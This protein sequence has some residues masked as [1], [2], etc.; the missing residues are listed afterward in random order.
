[1]TE[2]TQPAR[3]RNTASSPIGKF[4]KKLRIDHDEVSTQMAGRLGVSTN[5]LSDV[6]TGKKPVP[7]SWPALIAEHY[8]LSGAALEELRRVAVPSSYT[9]KLSPE[10]TPLQRAAAEAVAQRWGRIDDDGAVALLE[11]LDDITPDAPE[12]TPA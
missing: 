9:I 7:D 4:L 2:T 6:E 5:L 1:M 12:V 8:E 10:A 3:T 11:L